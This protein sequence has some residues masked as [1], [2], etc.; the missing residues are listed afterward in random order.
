MKGK[1]LKPYDIDM[2]HT[3][4]AGAEIEIVDGYCGCNGYVYQCVMPDGTQ[5]L[6]NSDDIEITDQKP[7]VDWEI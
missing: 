1:L 7:Y 2:N 6:L 4:C 3:V 5:K